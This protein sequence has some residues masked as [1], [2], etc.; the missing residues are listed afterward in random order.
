[1][2]GYPLKITGA[3]CLG[4]LSCGP[5]PGTTGG[6]GSTGFALTDSTAQTTDD[7]SSGDGMTDSSTS[8]A[9]G[10]SSSG[11][12]GDEPMVCTNFGQV[13]EEFLVCQCSCDTDPECCTCQPQ[14]CTDNGHCA[15]D[16]ICSNAVGWLCVPAVC[17]GSSFS[18]AYI[19]SE[20]DA[21]RWSGEACLSRVAVQDSS[22]IDL[23]ALTG[24]E[25][26]HHT[27]RVDSNG[28]LGSLTGLESLSS[29]GLLFV[30][31]NAVL[32]SLDGLAGLQTIGEGGEIRDNPMLDRAEID[33]F[34]AG[35]DGGD[36]VVV[37]GNLNDA[38]C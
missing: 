38:P 21:Q 8:S 31:G 13:C 14:E 6:D 22:L 11:S 37:C 18:E 16:E 29:T 10:G 1:M 36:A 2:A 20:Q 12:T 33:A 35:V 24:L 9:D 3:A 7:A 26:I 23:S 19:R 4:A 5:G 15:D 32:N 34:L 25:Y 17:D 27:L 28:M 30:D